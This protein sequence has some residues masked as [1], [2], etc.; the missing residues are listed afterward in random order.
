MTDVVQPWVRRWLRGVH[1]RSDPACERHRTPWLPW[2]RRY[3]DG[4]SCIPCRL[5]ADQGAWRRSVD[6]AHP[7]REEAT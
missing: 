4:A 6:L 3:V 1:F 5:I 2:A 7:P